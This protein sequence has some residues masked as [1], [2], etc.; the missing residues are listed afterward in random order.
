MHPDDIPLMAVNTPW[1]LYEWLVMPMGIKNAPSIHQCC[2][3]AAL[4][5]FIGK[6]CHVY[7][8]DIVI[9]SENLDEHVKNVRTILQ[10]LEDAK[11]FCTEIIF[12]G[13][14]ISARGIEPDEGDKGKADH[15]KAWPT[16]SSSSDVR[17]FLGLVRYLAV[18]LPKLAKHTVILDELTHK[19]CD[20][21][22]PGWN[23]RHQ[24]T[25][26]SIKKLVTSSACLTT[27]DPRLIPNHKIFVTTDASDTGSGAILSFGPSYKLARP[28]A[29]DSHSFKG[30]ELNYPVHEKELLAIIRALA[31]WRTDLLS[32]RFEIWTDH[33]TLIHFDNQRD[34]SRHQAQWMEFLS[35]Y[36][37]SINYIPGDENC[38]AD[39][40]PGYPKRL[41]SMSLLSF[42]QHLLVLPLRLWIWTQISLTQ[43]K[44]ATIPTL[45]FLNS[46]ARPQGST[47]FPRKMISGSLTIDL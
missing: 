28:V 33:K 27:I 47:S 37:A 17:S 4:R 1:G 5:P 30:A 40:L 6:I 16:P 13:H 3:T 18:F 35:Q 39:A 34:L 41:Y 19:E 45:S 7:L 32:Y 43:L 20:K 2:V 42:H 21:E 10:A 25:F 26:D 38:M 15:I 14:W 31:K 11:L 44:I 23:D 22:F 46:L 36:D 12:L 29:Y 24:L 8:D 9:W